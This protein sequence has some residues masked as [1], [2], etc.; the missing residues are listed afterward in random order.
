MG[1][2][3]FTTLLTNSAIFYWIVLCI[4]AFIFFPGRASILYGSIMGDWGALATKLARIHPLTYLPG[5]IFAFGGVLLYS[6]SNI[7]AGSFILFGVKGRIETGRFADTPRTGLIGTAFLAGQALFSVVFLT[8]AIARQLAPVHVVLVIVMALLVGGRPCSQLLGPLLRRGRS[9]KLA[10]LGSAGSMAVALLSVAV[11]SLSLLYTTA[12]LSYDSVALYFSDAKITALTH[13]IQ[14]FLGDSFIVSS[15]QTGIHF[16]ALIQV[17]GDQAARMYS[18]INGLVIIVFALALGQ[19]IGL[20]RRARLMLIVLIVT[21]TAF[22]DLMGDGKVDLASTAPALG[23]VYWM[24]AN[25]R[26]ASALRSMLMGSFAGLAMI[27]RPFNILLLPIFMA[28]FY[29]R[30]GISRKNSH[31]DRL[32]VGGLHS[33]LLAGMCV[34]IVLGYHLIDNW[35]I[36]GHPMA[37]VLDYQK[38]SSARWQWA[39]DPRQLNIARLLYPLAVTYINSPQSLGNVSPLAVAFLPVLLLREIRHKFSPSEELKFLFFAAAASLAAWLILY[40]TVVE[41]RYVLFLWIVLFLPVSVLLDNAAG[42]LEALLRYTTVAVIVVLLTFIAARAVYVSVDTYAPIDS[43]GNAHCYDIAMC[44]FLDPLNAAASPGE[45]VL[46]L[47]AYRYY[48]R[49]DLFACS[50]TH[51]EYARLQVFAAESSDAFWQEVYREGYAYLTYERNY[52]VRHLYM[53]MVPSP[54]NAPSWLQLLPISGAPGDAEVAYKIQVINP[55]P[56]PRAACKLDTQGIWQVAIA[57]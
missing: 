55:P 49:N 31:E 5:M 12:R 32:P 42:A 54:S 1:R 28:V 24:V 33:I 47:N 44:A 22:L 15:L 56:G 53:T 23:A 6:V 20:S 52:S 9:P 41:I 35:A 39:L 34:L 3:R 50:T 18:W 40:F 38:L 57:P 8:L 10:D 29:A 30:A 45:R 27:A 14:F 26:E 25:K 13:G 36:L 17:F 7:A 19:E 37:P 21:S 51:N 2:A 11:I 4:A 16:S 48:L 46:T 43:R